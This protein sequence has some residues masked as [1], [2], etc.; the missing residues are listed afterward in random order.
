[1]QR[2]WSQLWCALRFAGD[3]VLNRQAASALCSASNI[4]DDSCL[5]PSST[6]L[7][8]AGSLAVG[9][10][11]HPLY[12]GIN[13][14]GRESDDADRNRERLVDWRA[15]HGGGVPVSALLLRFASI[16][17]KH[18]IICESS[19]TVRHDDRLLPGHLLKPCIS[20]RPFSCCR[21]GG[22]PPCLC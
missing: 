20:Q 14:I 19:E 15:K 11:S 18:G 12:K 10:N 22:Q 17:S 5:M 13:I 7:L 21:H 8:Q 2:V 1:M 4:S 9:G 3:N 6:N 16:S